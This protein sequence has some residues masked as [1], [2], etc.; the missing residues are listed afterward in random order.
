VFLILVV[1]SERR[2]RQGESCGLFTSAA[3]FTENLPAKFLYVFA[4]LRDACPSTGRP[5][6]T[7]KKESPKGAK[8]EK[9]VG[10]YGRLNGNRRWNATLD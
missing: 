9:T 8:E 1:H 7:R 3:I 10:T 2:R 6:I 4:P 5:G